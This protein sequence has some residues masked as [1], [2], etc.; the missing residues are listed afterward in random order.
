M[1]TYRPR[2]WAAFHGG[3]W[4]KTAPEMP[5]VYYIA[6]R[7]GVVCGTRRWSTN[8]FG[9]VVEEGRAPGERWQGWFWSVAVP[10]AP[11]LPVPEWE[12]N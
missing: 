2:P 8:A 12:A 5:G 11:N 4:I 6:N 7:E 9:K 1:T 3:R 10:D